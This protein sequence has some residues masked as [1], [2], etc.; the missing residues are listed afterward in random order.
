MNKQCMK[1]QIKIQD[2]IAKKIAP[3]FPQM[4][5][6]FCLRDFLLNMN[7]KNKKIQGYYESSNSGF[8]NESVSVMKVSTVFQLKS[9]IRFKNYY[10]KTGPEKAANILRCH[11]HV[12]FSH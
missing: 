6:A 9:L 3:I 10:M 8:A 12:R 2:Q 1:K 5:H 11:L 7:V 4:C